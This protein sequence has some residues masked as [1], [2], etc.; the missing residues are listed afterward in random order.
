MILA[1]SGRVET[2]RQLFQRSLAISEQ[3]ATWHNLAVVEVRLGNADAA[4]RAEHRAEQL[5]APGW[6]P[7]PETI[8]GRVD[9]KT[10]AATTSPTDG[11]LPPAA[12]PGPTAA[13]PAAPAATK[14]TDRARVSLESRRAAL[15]N[16]T[17]IRCAVKEHTSMGW[18]VAKKWRWIAAG[19]LAGGA[20]AA[21][22]DPSGQPLPGT[23]RRGAKQVVVR[24]AAKPA[25]A[26]AS[27]DPIL[28]CQAL[29]PAAPC[30]VP[31]KDCVGAAGNP[32]VEM[33]GPL[34]FQKYAQGEYVGRS[35]IP[36]V[37]EYR[38]RVD[39]QLDFIYRLTRKKRAS[40]TS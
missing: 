23:A 15:K 22:I 13:T 38:L 29:S 35:R 7:L 2:A 34:E 40:R 33:L 12:V 31:Y 30:P 3:A 21:T 32:Q 36:H 10:F 1:E 37:P 18:H 24:A 9:A 11:L 20:A 16:R 4:A 25:A 27:V 28:L 26:A 14:K 19:L 17:L 5:A 39:D 8:C 6:V